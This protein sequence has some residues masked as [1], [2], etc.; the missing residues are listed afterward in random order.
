MVC[1]VMILQRHELCKVWTA[2]HKLC[3]LWTALHNLAC[4]NQSVSCPPDCNGSLYILCNLCSGAGAMQQQ[5]AV[6]S[7]MR[8]CITAVG[9]FT[10]RTPGAHFGLCKLQVGMMATSGVQ[11]LL[12]L[13]LLRRQVYSSCTHCLS[14]CQHAGWLCAQTR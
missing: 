10:E 11:L 5:A 7:F 6:L 4:D 2:L 3:K 9:S 1:T 14:R 8:V 13:L 12:Q